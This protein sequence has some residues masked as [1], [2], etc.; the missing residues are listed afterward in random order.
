VLHGLGRAVL[1]TALQVRQVGPFGT[2]EA[3]ARRLRKLAALGYV[4]VFR[5]T[6]KTKPHRYGLTE[7][8]KDKVLEEMPQGAVW[9]KDLHIAKGI[10]RTDLEH[11]RLLADIRIGLG[12]A[13]DKSDHLRLVEFMGEAD[14]RQLS[15][16][17]KEMLIPDAFFV[18]EAREESQLGFWLELDRG[19][20]SGR[21]FVQEK[22]DPLLEHQQGRRPAF[23]ITAWAVL[24]L[25][26][27]ERRRDTLVRHLH[28]RLPGTTGLFFALAHDFLRDP[29][30]RLW[31]P[32]YPGE[33]R[34]APFRPAVQAL[35][36]LD[37]LFQQGV[38]AV[39]TTDREN[40]TAI[41]RD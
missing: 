17:N 39:G 4:S 34:R 11:L 37:I 8:G 33:G 10:A 22:L 24:V 9:P 41:P 26:E 14:I 1:L 32:L 25:I 20:E 30:G 35:S 6:D 16:N 2:R 21:R 28:G 13:C 40:L 3:A 31:L 36:L 7:K 38:P 23:G 19:K 29:L 27:K 15:H 18:L 5:P 12:L